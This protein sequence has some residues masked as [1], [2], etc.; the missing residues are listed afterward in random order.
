MDHDYW[1][2]HN[3]EA[4]LRAEKT[5][6]ELRERRQAE[7]ERVENA[8]MDALFSKG[9]HAGADAELRAPHH[10]RSACRQRGARQHQPGLRSVLGAPRSQ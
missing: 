8:L 1:H 3:E 9:G 2:E 4:F 5:L 6:K 7:Y 10:C